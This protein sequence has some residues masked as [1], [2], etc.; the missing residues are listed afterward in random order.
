MSQCKKYRKWFNKNVNF[1]I[2]IL[3]H[4]VG[5]LKNGIEKKVTSIN[6]VRLNKLLLNR[7]YNW[8]VFL[9]LN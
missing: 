8:K 3:K 4:E 1:R 2:H 7:K 9:L 5:F 6:L